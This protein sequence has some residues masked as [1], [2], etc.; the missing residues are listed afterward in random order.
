M[1]LV[2]SFATLLALTATAPA[3]PCAEIPLLPKVVTPSGAVVP[4][5]GGVLIGLASYNEQIAGLQSRSVE[6]ASWR[7]DVS[8]KRIAPKAIRV[9]APGLAVYELPDT[10]DALT[11]VDGSQKLV[12]IK[13]GTAATLAAPKVVGAVHATHAQVHGYASTSLELEL[14]SVPPA[15]AVAMI[16]YDDKG[17][18]AWTRIVDSYAQV[19]SLNDVPRMKK[20]NA[21]AL[22]GKCA[23][24]DMPGFRD[25]PA[26]TKISIAFVDAA[27]RTSA[28]SNELVVKSDPSELGPPRPPLP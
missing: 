25:V 27:G 5:G 16:V 10:G 11:L 22:G 15:N 8:G 21:Y 13:R 6:Q 2:S 3:G 26:G 18:I 28:R 1:Q 9:L 12:A 19:A 20:I 14:A 24:Q 17:A 4:S 23:S 7:F